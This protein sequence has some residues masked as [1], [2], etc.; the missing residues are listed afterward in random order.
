[1]G[2]TTDKVPVYRSP[3]AAGSVAARHRASASADKRIE[4]AIG[5]PITDPPPT[6]A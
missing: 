4:D 2:A 3:R 5:D 1:M 6:A